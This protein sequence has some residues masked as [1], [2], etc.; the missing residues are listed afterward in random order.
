MDELIKY[1][2]STF[3]GSNLSPSE[4]DF[5]SEYHLRLE[6]G[7]GFEN[8]TLERVDQSTARAKT[9]FEVFFAQ[10]DDVWVW[11][12]KCDLDGGLEFFSATEGYFEQ[13]ILDYSTLDVQHR[14]EV[15]VEDEYEVVNDDGVTETIKPI[16][17]FKQKLVKIKYENILRAIANLEMGFEPAINE[18]IFFINKRNNA[19]FFYVR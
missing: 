19:V 18:R 1:L 16:L 17:T 7:E 12:N 13:Q 10:D 14:E 6:L 11:V 3:A 9:I 2:Q 4:F 5:S 15:V 8:G